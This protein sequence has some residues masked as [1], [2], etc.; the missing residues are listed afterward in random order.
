MTFTKVSADA[1]LTAGNEEYTYAGATY[2]IYDAATDKLATTI[3]TDEH[4]HATCDLTF[5]SYYAKETK[6]PKGFALNPENQ[7]FEI[8]ESSATAE[9]ELTDTPG[10]VSITIQKRD[11]ATG[12]SAQPGTSFEGAEYTVVDANGVAHT[13]A[14]DEQGCVRIDGLPLGTTTITETKAPEGYQLDTRVHTY[15]VHA[16]DLDASGVVELEPVDDFAE[17]VIAFDL[18][19]AKDT[20]LRYSLGG[21]GRSRRARRGR[22]LRDHLEH[23][24][25]VVGAITTGKDGFA[26]T[27]DDPTLWFGGGHAAGGGLGSHPL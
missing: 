6:A 21:D 23:H 5:G 24:G 18:E 22:A 19:I 7:H 16:E 13:A 2:E 3:T 8:L 15:T 9:V 14:T 26:S 25:S 17:D 4:G 11:S 12:Q 1:S 10:S 27:A 20:G